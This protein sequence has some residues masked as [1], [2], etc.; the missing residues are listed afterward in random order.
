MRTPE[1]QNR[2][3]SNSGQSELNPNDI[4]LRH[5]G[6][7]LDTSR[8][9]V[10]YRD[11]DTTVTSALKVPAVTSG[12]DSPLWTEASRGI[13]LLSGQLDRWLASRGAELVAIRRHIHAHPELSGQEFETAAL[14]ARELTRAGLKPRLL[15]KGNGV[16]CDI[17]RGDRVVALRADLDALPLPDTKDVPYRSTVDNVCHACGHDVHTT[18]LLGAGL[19]LAE[20]EARGEL[21][22]R[23]RL[24]FQPSEEQFPSGASEVIAEG[25]LA[26]V[27]SIYAMHCYPQL[28]AGVVAARS[29]PL[30]AAT[31]V[32]EVHLSGLGGHTARPHLTGDLV[33]AL[34]RVVVDVP[35][36]LSR[37]TDPRSALSLV[38]GAVRAG[39]AANTIPIEGFARGTVRVLDRDVWRELPQLVPQLVHDALVG[40]SVQARVDYQRGVP[41]VVNDREATALMAGAA[42]AALGPDQVV[43]AE[44]SMG[45]ED[46]AFYVDRVPGTMIRLGVGLPGREHGDIHQSGF[47]VD[48]RAIDHGVRVFVHTALAAASAGSA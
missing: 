12:L 30:T 4:A 2:D 14:V 34:A 18:V 48:E 47:D 40:T 42:A 46:F 36:M 35:A 37:R 43:E 24:L 13:D 29:G 19:A 5:R 3:M 32:V 44:V 22:G 26:D 27:S 11:R 7:R 15:T 31:D 10:A 45:G 39:E 1:A 28:P 41:P 9:T 23:I 8:V 20:L 21:P 25:G 17:G 16:I 6:A 33:H 38:F